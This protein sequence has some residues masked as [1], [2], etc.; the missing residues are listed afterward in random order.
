MILSMT[1]IKINLDPYCIAYDSA[2]IV[3]DM[4][5][6]VSGFIKVRTSWELNSYS[7]PLIKSETG[8]DI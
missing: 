7:R 4:M 2:L 1:M 5:L 3:T 8:T 6:F